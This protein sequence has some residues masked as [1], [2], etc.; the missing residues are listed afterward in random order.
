MLIASLSALKHAS[1]WAGSSV[2]AQW[3][4]GRCPE[5]YRR[6]MLTVYIAHTETQPRSPASTAQ[7]MVLWMRALK[8][9]SA[10]ACESLL[11]GQRQLVNARAR[12][13][14]PTTLFN[15]LSSRLYLV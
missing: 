5:R 12:E 6:S 2:T 4:V 8:R 3:Q 13:R 7:V 11:Q 10:A 1:I 14:R 15:S 9:A